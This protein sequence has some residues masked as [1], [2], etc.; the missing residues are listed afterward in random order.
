MRQK[1]EKEQKKNLSPEF[2][3]L[4]GLTALIT[5]S[6]AKLAQNKIPSLLGI[7]GYMISHTENKMIFWGIRKTLC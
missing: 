1:N 2:S 5:P 4:K 6:K 7:K 3:S